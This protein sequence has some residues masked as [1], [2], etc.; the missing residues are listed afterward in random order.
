MWGVKRTVFKLQVRTF[1]S[2]D[3]W[4]KYHEI[5]MWSDYINS[6]TKHCM[7][8]SSEAM[9]QISDILQLR[10]VRVCLVNSV[11]QYV[12]CCQKTL[13][14]LLCL[15]VTSLVLLTWYLMNT[16]IITGRIYIEVYSIQYRITEDGHYINGIFC[17]CFFFTF[18]QTKL[19][20][21]YIEMA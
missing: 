20:Q 14:F 18:F 17:Q 15:C 21:S 7:E 13:T 6:D 1:T 4:R 19:Y 16:M 2:C 9:C 12:W 5:K 3:Q 8:C 10:E 11:S